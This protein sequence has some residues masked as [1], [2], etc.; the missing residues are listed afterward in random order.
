M[1]S[2]KEALEAGDLAALGALSP[3]GET[4]DVGV[5]VCPRCGRAGTIDIAFW[6]KPGVQPVAHVTYPGGAMPVF[7]RLCKQV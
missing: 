3:E 5:A 2:A 6:A 7:E 1:Q 4:I